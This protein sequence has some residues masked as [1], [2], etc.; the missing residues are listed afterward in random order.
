[1]KDNSKRGSE[2]N[3]SPDKRKANN[4]NSSSSFSP[5]KYGESGYKKEGSF[6]KANEDKPYGRKR[7]N[8]SSYG[9]E[10]P[11]VFKRREDSDKGSYKGDKKP[12]S[13]KFSP[14]NE[15][16]FGKREDGA[17]SGYSKRP[18]GKRED[19]RGAGTGFKKTYGKR[20]EER[21]AGTG[22]KKTY[23]KRED[24]ASSGYDKRP[25]GKRE[26]ERGAGTGYK[27]T[28]GKREDGASS[29][30]NKRP[31]GKREDERG[32]GT[33]FKKTYGKR[34]DERGAGTGYK[35][36][37]GKREDE[38]GTGSGYGKKPFDKT[39]SGEK[40]FG[41]RNDNAENNSERSF[42]KSYSENSR[43]SKRE[44]PRGDFAP[45][46]RPRS[47]D[48][49][50]QRDSR[51]GRGPNVKSETTWPMRLNRY[52]A[53]SGICARR[54]ADKLIEQGVV[55][56]N[57]VVVTELGAKVQ[58]GDNIKVDGRK[59]QPEKPIYMIMNKPKDCITTTDDEEGRH[60]VMDLVKNFTDQRVYP[61]GRLDRNT[62]GVLLL[63]ND[64]DLAQKLT[65]PSFEVR[66]L[67][68][69][70]LDKNANNGVLE[71]LLKGVELE[72]GV[73]AADSVAFPDPS[74]KK[75][76]GIEIHSGKNRV[77]RRMFE[78][79]GFEVEKLD[80]VMFGPFT[81]KN[82]AR[83]KFRLLTDHELGLLK[84]AKKR[85]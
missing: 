3:Y 51:V 25:Y 35:K 50:G 78:A 43:F 5:K 24:G 64:G 55:K 82:I 31:Y 80:R 18:Y 60:T 57:G 42:K 30:Y 68:Q 76:I 36:T 73:V 44:N 26:D 41:P 23:S 8:D 38:R 32:E 4:K 70:T 74:D 58:E 37:Y 56:V 22:Y 14:K 79:L 61:V 2:K 16:G 19:E 75:N 77:I 49:T 69:V 84:K 15:G 46:Y 53:M 85:I 28:Y 1:M 17:S 48:N 40:R 72:D 11:R 63:T 47:K 66:K 62:T 6:K 12:Y 34:E 71:Q 39:Q 81:K 20:E 52:I 54:E 29:G 10:N 13:S 21:G 7:T 27:K 59:I 83:G 33:G 45:S 9:S 67:Y 65:H